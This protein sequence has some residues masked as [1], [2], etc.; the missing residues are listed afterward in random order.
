[1]SA[2]KVGGRPLH[3]R[4]RRGEDVEV[5][6]R[7]VFV[8]E[9]EILAV[10]PEGPGAPSID[11]R[12]RVDKGFYVRSLGRD[13]AE[14][15]GT[16]GHLSALRRIRSGSFD[17]TNAVSTSRVR[18]AAGGDPM[19]KMQITGALLTLPEAWSGPK[20]TLDGDGLLDARNG[21]RVPPSRCGEIEGSA[22][23][24]DVVAMLDARGELV[25]LGALEEDGSLK[26]RRGFASTGDDT[27]GRFSA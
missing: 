10:R 25:A 14:A 11:L 19:A 15:L 27:E 21:R 26:V 20:T 13:L 24:G 5:P 7:D 22:E 2:I 16:V 18:E 1:V 9:L 4:V 8:H 6:E 12:V 3:E 23:A 17:L